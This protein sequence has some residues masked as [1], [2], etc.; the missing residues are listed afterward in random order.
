MK[1]PP[2]RKGNNRLLHHSI[3]E[4]APSMKVPPKRE[5]NGLGVLQIEHSVVPSMKVPPKRKGN[6]ALRWASELPTRTPQ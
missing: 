6:R 3:I 2:K 1:V 4:Q 5:G